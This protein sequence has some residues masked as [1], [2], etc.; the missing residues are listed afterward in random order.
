MKM[1][2][3]NV[4]S[5]SFKCQLLDMPSEKQLA[6]AKVERLGTDNATVEW[7]ERSGSI[8]KK[9]TPLPS[10]NTAISFVLDKLADPSTGVLSSLSDLDSVAFKPVYAKGITGCQYMDQRVLD[11]MAEFNSVVAPLH[12]PAYIDAIE[13]FTKALPNTPMVG[14]FEDFFFDQMPEYMTIYPIPW[15]WTEKYGI[16]KRLW[17][18]ASHCYAT[19]R[20]TELMGCQPQDV[21]LITCHLGGSSSIMAIRKGIGIDG[22]GGFTLQNG[23]PQSVRPG[24][25]D[26]F[27]VAYLVTQGEGTVEDVIQRLMTEGGLA[28]ISGIGFDMRDLQ[29]AAE[30]GHKRAQ[31][32]IDCYVHSV[33]KYVG[34]WMAV[35]GH[36]DAI[37]MQGGTGEASPYIRKR[38]LEGLEEFGIVLDNKRNEDC[39]G[40]ECKISADSSRTPI[41]V[42]QANEEIV[43]AREC[44]K[45]LAG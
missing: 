39:V 24:D 37:T 44:Y 41:W 28:A 13:N 43:V 42:I 18:G 25:L 45:L 17:H 23:V 31:L 1:L 30:S 6:R 21:N 26:P 12:N 3:A 27:L 5:S 15:D 8:R 36:V 11:A 32:A 16:R 22:C 14:L 35:L 2:V 4:G 29:K 9:E 10:Y 34:S 38:V 20:V 33:R 40:K 19:N 7:T